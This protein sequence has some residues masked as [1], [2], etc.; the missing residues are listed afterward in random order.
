MDRQGDRLVSLRM[1]SPVHM[2]E[3]VSTVMVYYLVAV[4]RKE[5]GCAGGGGHATVNICCKALTRDCPYRKQVGK[6]RPQEG[7]R[8]MRGSPTN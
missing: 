7:R 3:Y 1:P 2:L 6:V 4:K 8:R 5:D